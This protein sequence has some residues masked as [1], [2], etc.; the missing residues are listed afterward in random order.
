MKGESKKQISKEELEEEINKLDI[1]VVPTPKIDNIKSDLTFKLIVVGNPNSGKSLLS[2]RGKTGKLEDSYDTTVGFDFDSFFSKID[3]QLIRLQIWETCGQEGYRSLV[4][5]FYRGTAIAIIV[6]SIN[7]IKSFND[8]GT[9]AKQIRAYSNPDCQMILI[10]TNDIENERQISE[11][12][13]KKCSED[14]GFVYFS[15]ISPK[16]FNCKEIY[17]KAIKLCYIKYNADKKSKNKKLG[18]ILLDKERKKKSAFAFL[19]VNKKIEGRLY[20]K[21]DKFL[22]KFPIENNKKD[23]AELNKY[24]NY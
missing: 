8:I 3:N 12:E 6:Y 4:Q 1:E 13:G 5:N 23:F 17:I 16:T 19:G 22:C 14:L 10:G 15:E 9:W 7:D 11:E 2:L 18:K 20:T 21:N 24:L